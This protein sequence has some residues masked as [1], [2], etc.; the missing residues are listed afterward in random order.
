MTAI[1]IDLTAG[2]VVLEAKIKAKSIATARLVLD[3]GASCV[4]LP[5]KLAQ[6]IGIKID[7]RKTSQTTTASAVETVL[8]VVIP[9]ISVLGKTAKNVKAIIKDLPPESHVDGLLGLSFLKNF[10]LNVDF[11]KGELFLE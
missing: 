3:T 1:K 5:L 8:E 7:P 11:K 6:A 2:V 10:K 9:E 4:V